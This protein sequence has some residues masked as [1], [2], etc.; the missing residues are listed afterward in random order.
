MSQ[1]LL[2]LRKSINKVLVGA[3]KLFYNF[4]KKIKGVKKS[5]IYYTDKNTKENN[6]QVFYPVNYKEEKFPIIFYFHGGGWI[7]YD[8]I[9]YNTLC[10]RLAK[11]GNIVI[12]VDYI[13]AP[14][15]KMY[16]LIGAC[17]KTIEYALGFAQANYNAD[18][19]VILA[20]DSAGAQIS[21]LIGGL[22]STCKLVELYPN[23]NLEHIDATLL[24]YGVY[25]FSTVEATNFPSIELML[26]AVFDNKNKE[27]EYKTFS[28]VNYV[29][30]NFPPCFVASGEVDK[31]HNLQSVEFVNKLEKENAKYQKLFF[32]KD[33][34]LAM[35][36]FMALDDLKTNKETLKQVKN[37]LD[38]LN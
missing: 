37:F 6:I 12:N 8:K 34:K 7:E 26:N 14:K 27:Q 36:G 20:G 9:I 30:S 3:S 35:H 16:D 38:N 33:E 25:D 28:P 29:T 5:K 17:I 10:K 18:S 24:F 23:S 1:F 32:A 2:T 13:L 22:V 11:M 19:K 31:L 21:A 15:V 4:D